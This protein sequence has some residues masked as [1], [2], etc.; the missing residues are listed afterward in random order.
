MYY[1]MD[2]RDN[3]QPQGGTNRLYPYAKD[4]YYHPDGILSMTIE[5]YDDISTKE[6]S[7]GFAPQG[8]LKEFLELINAD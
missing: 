2:M 4:L 7:F 3:L 8:N 1:F 5:I 6:F